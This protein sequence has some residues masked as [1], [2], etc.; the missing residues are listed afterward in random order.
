M[1]RIHKFVLPFPPSINGLYGGGSKQRRFPSKQYKEWLKKCPSL[2]PVMLDKVEIRYFYYFPDQRERDSQNYEKAITDF[3]VN[4]G[5]LVNDSWK[6]INLMTFIPMGVD[7]L[8]PRVEIEITQK[9]TEL[10]SN[11]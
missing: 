11:S 3:L 4:N 9:G 7:K 6:N 5:V 2:A 1:Q 8:N 10:A